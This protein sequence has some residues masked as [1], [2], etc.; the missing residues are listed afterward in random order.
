M[1]IPI[2]LMGLSDLPIFVSLDLFIPILV[3]EELLPTID[4]D[5]IVLTFE[6]MFPAFTE[7][8][9]GNSS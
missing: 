5:S 3:V 1:Q 7:L 2:V 4:V 8:L 6:I 9:S